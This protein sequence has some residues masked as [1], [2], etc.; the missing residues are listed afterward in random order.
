MLETTAVSGCKIP[1]S[2]IPTE[3]PTSLEKSGDMSSGVELNV[4][5]NHRMLVKYAVVTSVA[6]VVIMYYVN[7]YYQS[8]FIQLNSLYAQLCSTVIGIHVVVSEWFNMRS[9]T[10]VRGKRKEL[11]FTKEELKKYT[12]GSKGLYLA[13]LGKVY[14]VGKGE[15]F[16]GPSGSY[17]FFAGM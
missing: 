13:I 15:K 4:Q 8:T 3:V 7:E 17:H 5:Y 2:P 12:E 9:K 14:D 6:S 11:L 16:Y 10:V 1:A